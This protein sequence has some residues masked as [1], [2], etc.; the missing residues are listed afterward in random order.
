MKQEVFIFMFLKAQQVCTFVALP[1]LRYR[2]YALF[3]S[4]MEGRCVKVW[5]VMILLIKALGY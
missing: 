2:T 5:A 4:S 3:F 1:Y